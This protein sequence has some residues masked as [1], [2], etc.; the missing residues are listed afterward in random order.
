MR[1]RTVIASAVLAT[2]AIT[3]IILVAENGTRIPLQQRHKP[4]AALAVRMAN[5]TTSRYVDVSVPASDGVTLRGWYFE[6]ASWNRGAV[7]LLHGVADNRQG[8]M[9][10]ASF[11]LKH[12]YAVLLPDARGHGE[13]GGDSITYG[14]KERHDIK[15]WASWL[16]DEK[17]SERLYGLGESMGAAILIQASSIDPRIRALVAECAFSTFRDIA[18][19]RVAQ[20]VGLQQRA[21]WVFAPLIEPAFLYTRARYGVDLYQSSPTAA[22]RL[23]N[24]PVLLIHGTADTNIPSAHSERLGKVRPANTEL[25]LVPSAVHTQAY[26]SGPQEYERRVL[27]WFQ[28]F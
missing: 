25:W 20:L 8:V 3:A 17:R 5:L 2:I 11:L 14:W 4:D 13:S 18:Y 24:T 6:P 28:R 27:A 21:E 23:S 10:H 19:Y 9:A 12:G 16:I 26:G 1:L 22:L 7:I 15:L